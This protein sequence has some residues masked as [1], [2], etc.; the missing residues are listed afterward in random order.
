MLDNT[1]L[2]HST[3]YQHVSIILCCTISCC[4]NQHAITNGYSWLYYTMCASLYVM[5]YVMLYCITLSWFLL[6]SFAV[7]YCLIAYDI[8]VYCLRYIMVCC[9]DICAFPQSV[10]ITHGAGGSLCLGQ[11]TG[12][13]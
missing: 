7:L 6:L 9:D 12:R 13:S 2:C 1:I 3:S 11:Y 10:V 5:L 4:I 8:T